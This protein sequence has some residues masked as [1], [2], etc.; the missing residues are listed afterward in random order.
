MGKEITGMKITDVTVTLFAWENIP[1]KSYDAAVKMV[2]TNSD[3]GLVRIR[4]DEGLEGRGLLGLSLHPASLDAPHIVRFLKPILMGQDPLERERLYQDLSRMRAQVGTQAVC[5]VDVALWD[6]AGQMAGLP[7]HA[8]LGTFRNEIPVYASSEQHEAVEGYV[9]Q[10]LA[11]KEAGYHGYK[12]HPNQRWREDIAVCQAVRKA[13]GDD[14]ILM[15]DSRAGYDLG[16]AVKVGRSIQELGF[17]W[18]EEPLPYTD[19]Y[20]YQKLLQK[21]DIPVMATEFPAGWLDQY[22]PWIIN[23]ATDIL[24]GDVLLKGGITTLLK[25]AHLA[26]AFFMK[27]E[28]HHGSNA[29]NDVANLH[30]QMAIPNTTYMEVLLPHEAWW[31]GLVEDIEIDPEG[32]AH[33]PT[34]PGLGYEIDLDLVERKKIAV[35]S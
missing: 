12:L 29:V 1:L 22:A 31:Y 4:T 20:N 13:V 35:L 10:A 28:I 14:F 30:L 11:V 34:K 27:I 21:L 19:I 9:Q 17:L 6:L 15:L 5:A 26:E 3:L 33:A 7:I 24:R 32:F 16:Q 8:L 2:T 18:Y 25:V 23:R